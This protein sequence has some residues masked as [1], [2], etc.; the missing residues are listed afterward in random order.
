MIAVVEV[1][2]CGNIAIEDLFHETFAV[3]HFRKVRLVERGTS[4]GA[5][6]SNEGE[7]STDCSPAPLG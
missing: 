4:N 5:R 1:F 6:V 2:E 3:I 7:P